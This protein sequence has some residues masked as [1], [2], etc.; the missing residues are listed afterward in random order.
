MLEKTGKYEE[1]VKCYDKILSLYPEDNQ[2]KKS[3]EEA[4]KHT[5]KAPGE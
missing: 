1:A 4:I 3:R 5:N 2:A